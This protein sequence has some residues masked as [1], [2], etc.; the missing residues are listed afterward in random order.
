[1]SPDG[2]FVADNTNDGRTYVWELATG[3]QFG[4]VMQAD[5]QQYL[6]LS[7]SPNGKLLAVANSRSVALWDMT[8]RQ[9]LG[10]PVSGEDE[11]VFASAFSPDGNVVALGMPDGKIV[12]RDA[13]SG[14]TIRQLAAGGDVQTLA[15]SPDGRLLAAA[16]RETKIH[17]WDPSTGKPAG[18]PIDLGKA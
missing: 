8:G 12:L 1:V 5:T 4:A 16:G 2:R 18:T 10:R 11:V 14:R 7:W 15:F 13:G 6:D 3:E 17:L 9:A